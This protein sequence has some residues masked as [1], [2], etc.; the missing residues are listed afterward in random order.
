MRETRL[1]GPRRCCDGDDPPVPRDAQV[2]S[3]L[4][5]GRRAARKI[6]ADAAFWTNVVMGIGDVRDPVRSWEWTRGCNL[7]DDTL[8]ALYDFNPVAQVIVNAIIDDGLRRGFEAPGE[9]HE[10]LM[11][12]AREKGLVRAV[13]R[14]AKE[15]RAFGGAVMIADTGDDLAIPLPEDGTIR[16][17][18][19]RRF[20]VRSRRDVRPQYPYD[21]EEGAEWYV[22]Q[23]VQGGAQ[24]RVHR[25]RLKI[26]EGEPCTLRERVRREGWWVS[27]LEAVYAVMQSN[28]ASYDASV[29]IV[30]DLSQAVFKLH[31][32]VDA[33]SDDEGAEAEGFLTRVRNMDRARGLANAIVLDADKNES[34][35]QVGRVNPGAL[36]AILDKS[37]QRLA[38]VA[39]M[40]VTRLMGISPAGLNATG[41]ADAERWDDEC[42][43]YRARHIEGPM[44]W[45]L[46]LV[47][48]SAEIAVSKDEDL[49]TWPPLRQGTDEQLTE[50]RAKTATMYSSL[51][52]S[53]LLLPEEATRAM[54]ETGDFPEIELDEQKR[55]AKEDLADKLRAKLA[56]GG[57]PD[58]TGQQPSTPPGGEPG[59]GT[60]GTQA[61]KDGKSESP[62]N[63]RSADVQKLA[64]NGAQVQSLVTIAKDVAQGQLPVDTAI[65]IIATAFQMDEEEAR[66]L[67]GSSGSGF[68][69]SGGPDE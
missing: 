21:V 18:S 6:V 37:D 40:P 19:L 60:V 33:L 38:M 8:E 36:P 41:E 62:P 20:I 15:A 30:Q 48:Q 58:A 39:G 42:V 66:R 49:I 31:G 23:P 29:R 54:V 44:E 3:L 16:P 63:E 24:M 56:A 4:N 69:P 32:V 5:M 65:R 50:K 68:K 27:K 9:N 14:A 43:G 28:A 26:F 34:F 25:S 64:L 57:P 67:L 61:P 22:V 17:G 53:G 45:G 13:S 46:R 59:E 55:K 51:A 47:A 1:H 12:A 52:Q 2:M 7:P 10:E 35:D 11:K